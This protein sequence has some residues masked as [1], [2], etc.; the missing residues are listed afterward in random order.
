MPDPPAGAEKGD[1]VPTAEAPPAGVST[2]VIHTLG[3]KANQY[4]SHAISELLQA[5]GRFRAAAPEEPCDYVIINT[6]TVTSKSDRE[7]R[8]LIY[9]SRC[10]YPKARLVVT[11]CAATADP[12][13]LS[14]LS[15]IDLLLSNDEKFQLAAT[16]L[17]WQGE[18]APLPP[19]PEGPFPM[20]SD[21]AG[22]SRGYLKIQEGCDMRCS[23]CIVPAARGQS[24]SEDPRQVLER[25][26]RLKERGYAEIVLTGIH[27]GHYRAP[28]VDLLD[29]LRRIE[30][31][32]VH[33]RLRL[34]SLDPQEVSAAL[35]DF[36]ADSECFCRHLHLS[37]QSGADAILEAMNR[38]YRRQHLQ[39]LLDTLD[40][41]LP[42]LGLG[43]DLIAG[44]PGESDG[45]FRQTLALVEQSPLHYLHVFPFSA[46]QGTEAARLGN[47]V[48]ESLKK[49]RVAR[50][51]ELG[52]EKRQHFIRRFVGQTLACLFER[53]GE[54][55]E[56][57]TL[58]GFSRNYLPLA[59]AGRGTPPVGR[60]CPAV[61][62]RAEGM[63]LY[64]E[65]THG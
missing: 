57:K 51:R 13:A 34:S 26:R 15:E 6:C 35:I 1:L 32:K 12:S 62:V 36:L 21:F 54:T 38:P 56:T 14:K 5:S 59:V 44:F 4:D 64:V 22:R 42:D 19:P 46:R 47:R 43:A 39:T 10:R 18:A 23:Y 50:L 8:Q 11:G 40:R 65:P 2:F 48:P 3:C 53:H 24:R 7:A 9:Q 63:R 33:P 45:L 60:E 37:I 58:G 16:L 29:L 30:R 41:R 61:G 17:R 25:L 49:E 27:L 31:E 28:G 52:K 20:A 55:A